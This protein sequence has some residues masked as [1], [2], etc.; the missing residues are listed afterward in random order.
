[1]GFIKHAVEGLDLAEERLDS[2]ML[3]WQM[4]E[5]D[6]EGL[7]FTTSDWGVCSLLIC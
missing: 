5:D 3:R 1:V 6:L 7:L 4:G 2:S